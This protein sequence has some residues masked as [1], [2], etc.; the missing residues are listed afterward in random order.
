MRKRLSAAALAAL[1]VLSAVTVSV[2]AAD[3]ASVTAT[4]EDDGLIPDIDVSAIVMN[5]LAQ[6]QSATPVDIPV[7][8]DSDIDEQQVAQNI[9]ES[10]NE[11]DVAIQEYLSNRTTPSADRDV[12]AIRVCDGSD[13]ATVYAVS[14]V[15]D[16]DSDDEM[17]Y[18]NATVK[19]TTDRT[20]DEWIQLEWYAAQNTPEVIDT[21]TSE[22]VTDDEPVPKS[23]VKGELT[24]EYAGFV[25]SSFLGDSGDSV[26]QCGGDS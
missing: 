5:A 13:A 25:E 8:P 3:G 15:V 17:E 1:L 12:V 11:D 20:V 24:P 14:D 2:A 4:S 21:L 7:A 9:Q 6:A 23:Y 19:D 22:Y 18:T 16:A 26:P 10:L